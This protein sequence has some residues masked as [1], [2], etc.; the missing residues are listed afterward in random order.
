[1]PKESIKRY[2]Y[3]V[4]ANFRNNGEEYA[5]KIIDKARC[6]EHH[7]IIR[8]EVTI[9]KQISHKNIVSLI[10]NVETDQGWFLVIE[11]MKVSLETGNACC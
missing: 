8:N 9:L 11:F 6:N 3:Y 7:D 5:I 1:M 2:M 4:H 10:E